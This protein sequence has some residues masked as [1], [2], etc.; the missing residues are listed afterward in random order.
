MEQRKNFYLIFKEAVNNVLKYSDCR[1]L[2]VQVKAHNRRVELKVEDDGKGF[3]VAQM[4]VLAAKSLSGNGL[5][6]MKRRAAD[7]KGE[8]QIIRHGKG[9]T[10]S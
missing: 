8:C 2:Y 4:K 1:H 5:V 9:T 3:D 10:V 6:N 7:M